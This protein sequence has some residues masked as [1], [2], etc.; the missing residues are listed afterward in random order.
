[1]QANDHTQGGATLV[2]L[3]IAMVI[4][5]IVISQALLLYSNQQ[6]TYTGQG[7][8]IVIPSRRSC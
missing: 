7:S 6:K 3:L 2:E 1:M 8:L 4:T 5:A